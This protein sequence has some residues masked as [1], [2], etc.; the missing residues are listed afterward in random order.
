[1]VRLIAEAPSGKKV[2]ALL[3]RAEEIVLGL[4]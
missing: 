3:R 2:D 1:V 4:A